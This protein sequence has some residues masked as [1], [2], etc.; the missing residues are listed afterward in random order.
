MNQTVTFNKEQINELFSLTS[1][2]SLDF[3]LSRKLFIC[4]TPV[5]SLIEVFLFNGIEYGS[6]LSCTTSIIL[7]KDHDAY[8]T[9]Y[10][11]SMGQLQLPE[12]YTLLR[13]R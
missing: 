2:L 3:C 1:H 13:S 6:Q 11:A 5:A 10:Q 9:T 7:A 4:P 8:R 12:S